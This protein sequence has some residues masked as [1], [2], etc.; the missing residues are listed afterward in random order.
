MGFM[1][2]KLIQKIERSEQA[3][4]D[5]PDTL[6]ESHARIKALGDKV[7]ELDA[8]VSKLT[9]PWEKYKGYLIGAIIGFFVSFVLSYL[10]GLF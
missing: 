6:E 9:S 5:L 4:I 7:N 10:I 8:A 2:D 3:L 1:K